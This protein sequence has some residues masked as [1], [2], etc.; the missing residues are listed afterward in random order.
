MCNVVNRFSQFVAHPHCQQ[1]LASIWYAGLP[2]WRKRSFLSK[3]CIIVGLIVI[4]PISS[5]YYLVFPRS[6]FGELL[7]TPFMKFMYHSASFSVFLV[8]LMLASTNIGAGDRDIRPQQR[9]P[10]PTIL[11][12]LIVFYVMGKCA[13]TVTS[14]SP[15][16]Q[17]KYF[18]NPGLEYQGIDKIDKIRENQWIKGE[19]NRENQW[20]KGENNRENQWIKGEN[21]RENQWIKGENNR[22]NS[23]I[24]I[25]DYCNYIILVYNYIVT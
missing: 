2:G 11:E 10:P 3:I 8:L 21:N 15:G 20:I 25:L 12:S 19:N 13:V 18:L 14:H 24:V 4:L 9:G 1:L 22:E 23:W 5:I 6:K 7:R 17:G 16:N